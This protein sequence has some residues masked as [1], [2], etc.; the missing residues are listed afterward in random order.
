MTKDTTPTSGAADL[1]TAAQAVVDRWDT[2]LW[3]DVP[4]T[5]EYI[6]RLRAALAAGQATAAQAGAKLNYSVL[7]VYA[8]QHGID[9]NS[10]CVAVREASAQP[11]AQQGAAYAALPEPDIAVGNDG[12]ALIYTCKDI[13][14]E[15]Y[16]TAGQLRDFADAT[17]ALRASHGQAPAGAAH[18]ADS[19]PAVGYPPLPNL[20]GSDEQIWEAIFNWKTATPGADAVRKANK[21]EN[22][23]IG[24]MRAC[25]DADRAARAPADS[26]LEDAAL[27]DYLHSTG[28]TIEMLPG[29]VDFY[30]MRFRVGGLHSA[31]STNLR[32]AIDMARKQGE[33]Q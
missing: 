21:V 19:V 17:H 10:L 26:V 2:P 3:K 8:N 4:A 6:G 9:Y 16:Y 7:Y 27:L 14:G 1:R 23:I 13:V 18:A 22:A 5:A 15:P 30:P 11:A 24:T 29:E 12:R 31:V 28:S 25:V 20:D 32:E 33:K